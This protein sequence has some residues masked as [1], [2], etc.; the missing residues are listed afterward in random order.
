MYGIFIYLQSYIYHKFKPN[1]GKYSIYMKHLFF[2]F[3]FRWWDLRCDFFF[4]LI[5][6]GCSHGEQKHHAPFRIPSW[7]RV[8]INLDLR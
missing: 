7:V 2:F 8:S 1:V 5:F 3:D 6:F 4:G